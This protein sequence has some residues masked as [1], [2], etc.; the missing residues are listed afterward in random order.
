MLATSYRERRREP[1]QLP[2]PV[3]EQG[4]RADH[5]GGADGGLPDARVLV[6]VERDE[7]DRLPEA[8]V[9]GEATTET[10]RAHLREPGH[11]PSLV[12]TEH[13]IEPSG[14]GELACGLEAAQLI[15]ECRQRALDDDGRLV[16]VDRQ[17]SRERA[18]ERVGDAHP[19][20]TP[21]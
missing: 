19:T 14:F 17:S 5:Q 6:Q 8:H 1:L 7:L 11:P 12:R 2:L 13:R 20:G 9:V 15:G 21:S 3:A 4:R 18:R 16:T 10:E